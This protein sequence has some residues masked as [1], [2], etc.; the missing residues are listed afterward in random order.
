MMGCKLNF[1]TLK[2]SVFIYLSL[3][4]FTEGVE[5]FLIQPTAWYY[6]IKYLGESELFLGLT[7][8]SFS[9]GALL[10]SPI[11]GALDLKFRSPKMIALFC[12][13]ASFIGNLLYTIPVSGYFALFGRFLCGVGTAADG[14]ACAVL[15][16]GTTIEN[17]AKA[18]LYLEGLYC[19]GTICGPT[20]G[21]ALIFEVN[22]YGWKIN[23]GNSPGFILTFIWLTLLLYTLL[24]PRDL[25]ENAE[26]DRSVIEVE[27]DGDYEVSDETSEKIVEEVEEDS[28]ESGAPL[29]PMVLCL[30]YQVFLSFFVYT[31]ISFYVP[32]LMKF[33]LGLGLKFVKLIYLNSTLFTSILFFSTHFILQYISEQLLLFLS[34]FSQLMPLLITFYFG[35]FWN[36]A[37][38]VNES[39]LLLCSMLILGSIFINTPLVS[40]LLSRITPAKKASFYQ[41]LTYT[42]MHLGFCSSRLVAGAT[43]AKMPMTFA[44][45]AMAFCWLF[46]LTWLGYEYRNYR[47]VL[48][49]I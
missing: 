11:L 15:A 44:S 43:F 8:A 2:D 23:K 28:D 22:I 29:P 36:N 10:F 33:H 35:L 41:S 12:C 20:L 34:V 30:Y 3:R 45:A 19:F 4:L 49:E 16:T 1:T 6:I 24:L 37:T 17:R 14:I 47:L 39:Y 21:S 31:A 27:S 26:S 38:S 48:N 18:Y 32:L 7:M 25:T 40:S 5:E 46:G 42:A 9:A 13:C